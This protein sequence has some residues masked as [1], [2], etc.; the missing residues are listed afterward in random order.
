MLVL[1]IKKKK[2]GIKRLIIP[3]SQCYLFNQQNKMHYLWFPIMLLSLN[4]GFAH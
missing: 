2:I 4:T 3:K 1:N